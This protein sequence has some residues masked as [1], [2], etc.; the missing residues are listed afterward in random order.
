MDRQK[1][2]QKLKK[3]IKPKTVG[4][5]EYRVREEITKQA[6]EITR[7]QIKQGNKKR[8]EIKE[9][10]YGKNSEQSEKQQAGDNESVKKTRNERKQEKEGRRKTVF[11]TTVSFLSTQTIILQNNWLLQ[12]IDRPTICTVP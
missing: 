9:K 1:E 8:T 10:I 4:E 12:R 7:K 11:V 2:E 3:S 5:E 6:N